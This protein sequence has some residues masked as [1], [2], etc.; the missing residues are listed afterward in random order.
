VK[1]VL[2]ALS[3]FT[4][5]ANVRADDPASAA[6]PPTTIKVEGAPIATGLPQRF[7]G[8]K[9]VWDERYTRVDAAQFVITGAAVGVALATNIA[10]PHEKT[11]STG[12]SFDESVRNTV[13]FQTYTGRARARDAS[14]V[15]LGVMS[16]FP[17]IVDSLM[18]AYWYRG[19]A[20]VARQ[21][22]LI[23]AE[24]MSISAAIQGT[25]TWAVGRQRPYV[26]EC[27]DGIPT[28]TIDCNTS[29]E[30]RSFFSG[31]SSQAF[32]SAALIC[33]HHLELDLF[34]SSADAITCGLAMTAAASTAALRM[35]A[36]VHYLSDVLMGA[37]VGSLVG[38]G[39]PWVHH[40]RRGGGDNNKDAVQ[41]TI[42]PTVGGVAAVG[43]F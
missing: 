6:P 18:I 12:F 26:R 24:A 32:T 27:G 23:D 41:V 28:S 30:H 22:F 35:M 5:A 38:F 7:G 43:G 14:D 1:R 25:V 31:H 17:F 34:D 39:V 11:V 2:V 40:Y 37:A 9:L 3:V 19:S 15:V 20:D 16:A 33:A 10:K 29:S 4:L 42:V 13:R 8:K 36:D 21:M